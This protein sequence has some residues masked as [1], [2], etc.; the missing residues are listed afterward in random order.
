MK[1]LPLL[2]AV[3]LGA[4]LFVA[5]GVDIP[6]QEPD[7]SPLPLSTPAVSRGY[8][9]YVPKQ[10]T[11]SQQTAR[12]QAEQRLMRMEGHKW[13]GYDTLR[14]TLSAG[15]TY[16]SRYIAYSPFRGRFVTNGWGS[17]TWFW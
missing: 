11:L 15:F 16:D 9:E 7:Q 10:L 5:L 14:P 12:I 17:N 4:V 8:P 3:C 2:R 13:A 6:A 1:G